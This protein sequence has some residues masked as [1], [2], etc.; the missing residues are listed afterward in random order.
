MFYQIKKLIIA[1]NFKK[2]KKNEPFQLEESENYSLPSDADSSINNSYFFDAFDA[3]KKE[4]VIVRLGLRNGKESELFFYYKKDGHFYHQVKESYPAKKCPVKIHC[5]K[6]GETWEFSF[7]GELIEEKTQ[8]ALSCKLK[9][10]FEAKY[11]IFDFFHH[12]DS[13]SMIEAIAREKWTKEYLAEVSA[14]N[15]RH[16]EQTGRLTGSMNMDGVETPFDMPCVRDHSFGRRNW[17]YMDDHL[18]LCGFTEAGEVI[19]FSFVNYPSMKRILVGYSDI[20][21]EGNV[22]MTDYSLK[23]YRFEGGKGPDTL[24]IP[25]TFSNGKKMKF[26]CKRDENVTLTFGE[27]KYIFQE[28]VGRFDIDGMKGYGTIEYGFN[29]NPKR[30]NEDIKH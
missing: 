24:T 2:K 13:K 7:D 16:Y 15:Q 14:N 19:N 28:A 26:T 30:W 5:V 6:P 12:C 4:C 9:A 11:P 22:T 1:N 20:G 8:K 10:R 21:G 3:K 17:D 18:W 25:C 23:D 29:T 27:G